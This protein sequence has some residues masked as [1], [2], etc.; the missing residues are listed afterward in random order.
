[1]NTLVRGIALG[2]ARAGL[3]DDQARLTSA[4]EQL[5]ATLPTRDTE[6]AATW[7]DA[8]ACSNALRTDAQDEAPIDRSIANL[9]RL[10]RRQVLPPAV[11]LAACPIARCS[12]NLRN[13]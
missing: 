6:A 8:A 10:L 1:M 7:A 9:I 2:M 13:P 11:R 12:R 4:L 3:Q 5:E